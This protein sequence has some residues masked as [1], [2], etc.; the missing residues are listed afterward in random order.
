[1]NMHGASEYIEESSVEV[2]LPDTNLRRQVRIQIRSQA[3]VFPFDIDTFIDIYIELAQLHLTIEAC[4]QG[5]NHASAQDRSGVVERKFRS[6]KDCEGNANEN[7]GNDLPSTRASRL[8]GW[9]N[10]IFI[11]DSSDAKIC[12]EDSCTQIFPVTVSLMRTF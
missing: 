1:M 7:D 5:V 6:H 4:R 9:G 8:S 12:K 2:E 11:H 10:R 3:E